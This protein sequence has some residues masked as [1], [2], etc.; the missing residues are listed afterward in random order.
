MRL[1]VVA[2]D[3]A[4]YKSAVYLVHPMLRQPAYIKLLPLYRRVEFKT[5][6]FLHQSPASTAPTYLST[7][8]SDYLT[9]GR[10]HLLSLIHI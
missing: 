2:R 10:H 9:T 5:A 6:C 4:L 1:R 7:P 3:K 8:I